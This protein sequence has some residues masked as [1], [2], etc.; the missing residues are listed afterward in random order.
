MASLGEGKL[1]ASGNVMKRRIYVFPQG[2]GDGIMATA[3][4]ASYFAQTGHKMHLAHNQAS[5]F[6]NNPYV[7]C[8]SE[9]AVQNLTE[10]VIR[11]AEANGDQLI[12]ISYLV[13]QDAS[14]EVPMR[15][16][17]EKNML[18]R[19]AERVG[20]SGRFE[21]LPR[22]FLT[23]E[24]TLS[25]KMFESPPIAVFS[26]GIERYKTWD[27]RK[28][29][30][31]IAAFPEHTFIQLG[32]PGDDE[33]HGAKYLCGKLSLRQ[34]ASVL[35][36]SR[37]IIGPQGALIHL[38]RAVD[39]PAVILGPSAEPFPEMAY[40]EYRTVAPEKACPHCVKGGMFYA[41]CEC[42]ERCMEGISA[43]SVIDALGEE[44][45]SPRSVKPAATY[46][47]T[48]D[49]ANDLQD[50]HRQYDHG[51]RLTAILVTK[52]GTRRSVFMTLK[53]DSKGICTAIVQFNRECQFVSLNVSQNGLLAFMPYKASLWQ[54]RSQ[55]CSLPAEEIKIHGCLRLDS[56]DE[57]WFIP[58]KPL[59]CIS[60][61]K[62][63][64]LHDGDKLI[65]QLKT[66]DMH[67]CARAS[68]NAFG[69]I[70][71]KLNLPSMLA[72]LSKIYDNRWTRRLWGAGY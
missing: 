34:T 12:A 67:E 69:R 2:I 39:C 15:S 58:R 51:N 37:C 41:N 10:Q 7:E 25:G 49:P 33:I 5:L 9:Y 13:F 59:I 52:S 65:L 55:V 24:E 70:L 50:F 21:A 20:L 16:A 56:G 53:M 4:A 14:D 26:Q 71:V 62:V 19:M 46:Q 30:E 54:Y 48:P 40:P 35:A 27:R 63:I 64:G 1:N 61:A 6:E 8:H 44:L 38:A 17:P 42:P 66:K 29:E 3:I 32:A 60:F 28:M 43:E 68:S 47:I 18:C 11:Q 23:P 22:I 45:S 57:S 36:N 31:V 72:R